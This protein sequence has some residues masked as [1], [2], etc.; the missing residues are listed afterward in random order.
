MRR[1][2]APPPS[3]GEKHKMGSREVEE[4]GKGGGGLMMRAG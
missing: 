4:E 1:P 2:D 3:E